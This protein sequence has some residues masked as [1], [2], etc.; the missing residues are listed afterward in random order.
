MTDS[1]S[2][3]Y[4]SHARRALGQSG[5]Q[6]AVGAPA[7]EDVRV[8]LEAAIQSFRSGDFADARKQAGNALRDMP[9]QPLII[10]S[11]PCP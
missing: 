10:S 2:S 1:S 11:V 9:N 4:R 7:L 5:E 3:D 8:V 6:R